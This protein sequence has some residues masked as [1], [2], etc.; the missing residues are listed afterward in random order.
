MGQ[1]RDRWLSEFVVGR[2][3]WATVTRLAHHLLRS[4]TRASERMLNGGQSGWS[5][6]L[7]GNDCVVYQNRGWIHTASTIC[8]G[9][10]VVPITGVRGSDKQF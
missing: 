1:E 4:Y 10:P 5:Y 6:R 9:F 2:K 3:G 7:G 8:K